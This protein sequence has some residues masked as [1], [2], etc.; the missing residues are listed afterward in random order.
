[1]AV[2][3]KGRKKIEKILMIYDDILGDSQLKSHQSELSSF[4]CVS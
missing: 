2:D 3:K 4:T 1:M